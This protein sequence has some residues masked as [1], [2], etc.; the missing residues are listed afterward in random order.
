[1][2]WINRRTEEGVPGT[3]VLEYV[4]FYLGVLRTTLLTRIVVNYGVIVNDSNA[5][6]AG[7]KERHCSDLR[8]VDL[9]SYSP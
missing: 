1:M 7:D 8:P 5:Q 9:A 2:R 6:M 3:A 4:V